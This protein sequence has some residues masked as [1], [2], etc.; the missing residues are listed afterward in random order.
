MPSSWLTPYIQAWV[1]EFDGSPAYGPMA[2]YFAPLHKAYG[3]DEVLVRWKAYLKQADPMYANPAR[4][5][6]TWG[7]WRPKQ[8]HKDLRTVR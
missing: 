2:K 6:Q 1:D 4:F 7:A 3:V 8:V 5:S